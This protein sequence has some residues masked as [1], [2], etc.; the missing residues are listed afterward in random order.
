MTMAVTDFT[1]M[2]D[3]LQ[4]LIDKQANDDGSF[5]LPSVTAGNCTG[6]QYRRL[7]HVVNSNTGNES[8]ITFNRWASYN[9]PK[10]LVEYRVT[11]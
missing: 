6:H 2:Q 4:I 3:S 8:C 9:D 5:I 7:L 1:A 11:I 10:K